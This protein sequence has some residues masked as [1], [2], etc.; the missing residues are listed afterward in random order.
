MQNVI[1][2]CKFTNCCNFTVYGTQ[3]TEKLKINTFEALY[4]L[5]SYDD[6]ALGAF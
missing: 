4:S 3:D 1:F 2:Y 5:N 6:L